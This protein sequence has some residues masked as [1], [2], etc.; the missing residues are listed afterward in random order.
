[1]QTISKGTK[2]IIAVLACTTVIFA[3]LFGWQLASNGQAKTAG[4]F[5]DEMKIPYAVNLN[6]YGAA[7]VERQGDHAGSPYFYDVD[8]YNA[9]SGG[10][11]FIL[12]KFPTI[13]QTSW[14]SCGIS[15]TMMVMDYFDKLGD[16]NEETLAAL[17]TD[18][19]ALHDG[20]CLDQMIE[21][22]EAV[23]GFALETTYD[24]AGNLDA[25][26]MA[27]FRTHIEAGVPVLIGWNDWGAH[28]QV[29]IG[30]DTMGTEYEGDDVLIVADPFDTTDHNQ[31]GYGVYGMERFIY[32]YTFY[33]FFPE[34]EL[35]DKCF[36]AVKPA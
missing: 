23:G 16:W 8:F 33:D 20:T 6:D 28:W 17:R 9:Q 24:Y 13:Q 35:R 11:L 27:W 1:M 7:A 21:M 26:S 34:N 30:Y 36:V 5:T 19:S 32:N 18:H 2:I 3:A 25:I 15:S 10:G 29:A 22:L 14:W 31:D 12:P 4:N